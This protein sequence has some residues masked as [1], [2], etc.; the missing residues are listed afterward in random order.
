VSPRTTTSNLYRSAETWESRHRD[1]GRGRTRSVA[2]RCD[3]DRP[4]RWMD[5]PSSTYEDVL[6]L[7]HCYR[8]R[9]QVSL[10]IHRESY[11]VGRQWDAD[12]S[13]NGLEI[14]QAVLYSEADRRSR[15][16]SILIRGGV[17]MSISSRP[18]CRGL[19]FGLLSQS[20]GY[21]TFA[22]VCVRGDGRTRLL[23]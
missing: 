11:L 21:P 10:C 5:R 14:V 17:C 6:G 18:G 3:R 15:T 9:C 1:L 23:T 4:S 20:G 22:A 8:H 13:V 16:R 7:R 2:L 12:N 19:M